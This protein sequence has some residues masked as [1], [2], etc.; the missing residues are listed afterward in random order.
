MSDISYNHLKATK[1]YGN[2]YV[3]NRYEYYDSSGNPIPPYNIVSYGDLYVDRNLIVAGGI[4]GAT[5]TIGIGATGAQG[6]TGYTGATGAQGATG[7]NGSDSLW[8]VTGSNMYYTSGLVG[9]GKQAQ[10][11]STLDVSGNTY[12]KGNTIDLL[13]NQNGTINIGS[14]YGT[15]FTNSTS[16]TINLKGFLNMYGNPNGSIA[17][18]LDSANQLKAYGSV[19]FYGGTYFNS[20]VAFLNISTYSIQAF[21]GINSNRDITCGGFMRSSTGLCGPKIRNSSGELTSTITNSV[22]VNGVFIAPTYLDL[23]TRRITDIT[24]TYIDVSGNV[25]ISNGK[26]CVGKTTGTYDIDVSGNINCNYY[27]GNGSNITGFTSSQI[28]NLDA[29]KITSGN[30]YLNGDA[31]FNNLKSSTLICPTINNDVTFAGSNINFNNSGTITFATNKFILTPSYMYAYRGD[32][33][34]SSTTLS[35]PLRE[36]Y[37][38]GGASGN[39]TI[40]LP[41]TTGASYTK[42]YFKL[43]QNIT[44]TIQTSDASYYIYPINSVTGVNSITI[45]GTQN[46]TELMIYTGFNWYQLN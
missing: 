45:N 42:I 21:F 18:T 26:L 31:S 11:P 5:G 14:L 40:T 36:F 22:D 27:Y 9:V 46:A 17:M 33:I 32:V 29:S 4:T 34:N 35:T 12:V 7:A 39:L 37:L 15:T 13:T 25:S 8:G 2:T 10:Y 20:D 19:F 38:I 44:V 16:S 24:K 28:P 41:A 3:K 23:N 6:A 1:I 30:L 43:I